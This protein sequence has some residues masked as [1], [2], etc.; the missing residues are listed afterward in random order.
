MIAI[1]HSGD[2]QS[3]VYIVV[4][5]ETRNFVLFIVDDVEVFGVFSSHRKFLRVCDDFVFDGDRGGR[6]EEFDGDGKNSMFHWK[7]YGIFLL[8][9][10]EF[11]GNWGGIAVVDAFNF[12]GMCYDAFIVCGR[13]RR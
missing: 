4:Y 1:F 7:I 5:E 11:D 12:Y 8:K 6:V 10:T 2:S 3:R 13:W 9:A